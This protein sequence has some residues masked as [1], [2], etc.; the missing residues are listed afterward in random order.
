M[1]TFNTSLLDPRAEVTRAQMRQL[2]KRD[3]CSGTMRLALHL[4]NEEAARLEQLNPDTLGHDDG[5][6]RDLYWKK[7]AQSPEAAPY[8]VN[9]L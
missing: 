6:L 7:F 5:K 4:S 1:Q 9:D 2:D 3:L 8:R